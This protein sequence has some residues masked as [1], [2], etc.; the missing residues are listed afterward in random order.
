VKI[1]KVGL[2]GNGKMGKIY[3]SEI[4]KNRN[5]KII[6]ILDHKN[7]KRKPELI[8]KFF[9][10]KKINLIVI[11]SPIK[12]H[13]KYLEYAYEAKKNIIVEKPLVE[14]INQLKKLIQLNKNYKQKVMIHH[15]DVLNF[16]KL[17]FMK[18]FPNFNKIRMI[19]MFYG[20]K[21]LI[22][23]YKKPYFDWLPHPLSIIINFFGVPNKFKILKYSKK[24]RS[25]LILEKLKLA[26]ELNYFKILLNFSNEIKK[27]SKKII[28]YTKNKNK[29]YDGYS[30]NNKRSIK[31]L[32]EKFIKINKINDINTNIKVYEL[33]F[34]IDEKLT[35]K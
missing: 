5:F 20:K 31:L 27:S 30:N 13:F 11:S 15:N 25:K 8:K 33:L 26:L 22:N 14:K 29:T 10:S 21:E 19:K 34:K 2:I 4:K 18:D 24:I 6:N 7:L 1:F 23:S 28:V 32:L 9:N 17:N 3:T 35:K 12:T 16:E